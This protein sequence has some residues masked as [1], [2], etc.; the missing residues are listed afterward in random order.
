MPNELWMMQKRKKLEKY[1]MNFKLADSGVN[2]GVALGD[3]ITR[4]MDL[5]EWV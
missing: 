3:E 5:I 1:H 4:N 2:C